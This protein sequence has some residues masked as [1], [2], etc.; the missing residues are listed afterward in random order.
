M[1][2]RQQRITLHDVARH[3]GVSTMTVSRVINNAGRVSAATRQRVLAAIE[4]LDYRPSHAARSLATH[5]TFLLGVVVPDI[6]NPFFA[7]IV[8]GI[9]EVAWQRQYSVLLADTNET[10]DQERAVLGRMDDTLI[11]GLILCSSRL[12]EDELAAL[13]TRYKGVVLVNSPRPAGE[14]GIAVVHSHQERRAVVA[15]QHLLRSGRRRVGYV[16]LRHRAAYNIPVFLA[17]VQE[18][19]LALD[20]SWYAVAAP[21]WAGGYEGAR[22]LLEAH[23][24]LDAIIGGNDLMALGILRAVLE[25]GRRVPD[26]VAITGGDDTL[27]ASQATPPLTSFRVDARGM[28]QTAAAL[29]FERL[30]GREIF[31]P[32]GFEETLIVRVSAP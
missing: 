9:Q 22:R 15:A 21:T 27:L 26:D 25:S 18:E 31:E 17:A 4:A 28:G 30:E 11:D 8:R 32:V 29:L 3:V 14:P 24:D 13:L 12:P 23:P 19:G 6:T 7:E 5:R 1:A 20:E 16:A 2:K 10:P